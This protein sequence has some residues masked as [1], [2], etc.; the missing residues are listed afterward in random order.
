MSEAT[1]AKHQTNISE[2]VRG[3]LKMAAKDDQLAV[4]ALKK[5]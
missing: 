1:V 5:D 3:L 4:R 2:L